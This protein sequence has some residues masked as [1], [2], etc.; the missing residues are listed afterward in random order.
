MDQVSILIKLNLIVFSRLINN[1]IKRLLLQEKLK[2]MASFMVLGEI[3]EESLAL[4]TII[5]ESD[6]KSKDLDDIFDPDSRKKLRSKL[7]IIQ[8]KCVK[9]AKESLERN[10]QFSSSFRLQSR[11]L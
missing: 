1:I 9:K 4:I 2:I 5:D 11:Q 8:S 7:E 6:P 10:L 3:C